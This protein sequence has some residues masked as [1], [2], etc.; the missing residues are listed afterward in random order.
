MVIY[1]DS[2]KCIYLCHIFEY[3]NLYNQWGFRSFVQFN[4]LQNYPE[5]LLLIFV[6]INFRK[7]TVKPVLSYTCLI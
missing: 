3:L 5:S 7:T 4:L 1:E 2:W 6:Y